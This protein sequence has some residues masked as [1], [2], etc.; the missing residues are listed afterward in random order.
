MDFNLPDEVVAFAD[1]VRSF[2]DREI[3]PLVDDAEAKQRTPIELFPKA[4]KNG[5]LGL[6]YPVDVGGAGA[7]MLAEMTLRMELSKVCAGIASAL[8]VSSHLGSYP[9]FALGNPDQV[10]RWLRPILA[11]EKITSF[12]LTEPAAGSDVRGIQATAVRSDAGWVLNGR[13]MFITNGPICD[14]SIIVAYVDKS[15]GID[16]MA[17]FVVEQGT[18]GFDSTR[19]LEKMGHYSSEIGEIVLENVEV[20]AQNLLG[21]ER[22]GFHNVMK[23]LNGGRIVVAGGAIGV[24]EA[25]FEVARRYVT[26]R[27]AFGRKIAG[28]QAVQHKLA[29][30]ALDI[31]AAKQLTQWAAWLYD[32]DRN[33]TWEASMAKLYATEM[34]LRVTD[35]SLR[36]F[37]GYGYIKEFPIERYYR[38]ARMFNIVEG[39]SDIHRNVIARSLGV[40]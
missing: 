40:V 36:L 5:F 8:S 37:G 12:G 2:A 3:S 32:Q 29:D 20:P 25:A 4:G 30:M 10:D 15:A 13:K 19:R 35:L 21:P 14:L 16:G 22:G 18:E 11:G 1:S 9:I 34:V 17:L 26:E 31:Q 33:P 7:G 24:A 39:V 28:F 38:D 27:E 23:T 6:R